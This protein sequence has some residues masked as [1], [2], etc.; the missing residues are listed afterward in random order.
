MCWKFYVASRL[1]FQEEPGDVTSASQTVSSQT[2][3]TRTM[4]KKSKR[5]GGGTGDGAR[6]RT[7]ARGGTIGGDSNANTL[8]LVP[9]S[10]ARKASKSETMALLESVRPL[11]SLKGIDSTNEDP[12]KC[13]WC[14]GKIIFSL[15]SFHMV[16]C[17][18]RSCESCRDKIVSNSCEIKT[19]APDLLGQKR[20][21][22]CNVL[23]REKNATLMKE[24]KS[25]EAWAQ[26]LVAVKCFESDKHRL[27]TPK[28]AFDW[29][30][31]AA[32]QNHPESFWRLALMY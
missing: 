14:D 27:G 32:A 9:A 17:G 18:K 30:Q 13:A 26:Y 28:D 12:N 16:C 8:A 11:E 5:R 3:S 31:R 1:R 23:G 21:I 15:G 4:G 29:F 24:A 22:F 2:I 7:K 10:G 25:G 6:G 20:C 19:L